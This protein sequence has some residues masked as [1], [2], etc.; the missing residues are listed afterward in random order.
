MG[1]HRH[2]GLARGLQRLADASVDPGPP[3]R[4][5]AFVQRLPD[6]RVGEGVP[7]RLVGRLEQQPGGQRLLERVQEI[8]LLERD[9][10]LE[11]GDVEVAPDHRRHPQP[12]DCLRV[13]AV[14][15]PSDHLGDPL[16]E[17]EAL[18]LGGARSASANAGLSKVAHDLL[19]EE[20]VALRLRVQRASERPRGGLSRAGPHQL[21]RLSLAEAAD[22]ELRDET[23]AAQVGERVHNA[24]P[25]RLGPV[26]HQGQ[27]PRRLRRTGQMAQQ[28]QRRAAR[29]MQVVEDQQDRSTSRDRRE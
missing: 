4:G 5:H 23:L 9:E 20:R 24:L 27:Q 17:A 8:V 11:Q 6:Q 26:G 19:D 3:S 29:P 14:Q 12:L 2:R 15:A 28:Q 10:L 22:V 16:R 13:E 21:G 1:Q 7:A 18:E 25:G